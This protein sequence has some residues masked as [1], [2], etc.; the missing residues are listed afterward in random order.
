LILLLVLT[1]ACGLRVGAPT[2][3]APGAG[4]STQGTAGSGGHGSGI[5]GSV[6]TV[7]GSV[8]T[9]CTPGSQ[10]PG[11]T[12][13]TTTLPPLRACQRGTLTASAAL[14]P[15]HD[16]LAPI[17]LHVGARYRLTL[18]FPA[19]DGTASAP[20]SFDNGV[21]KV[22]SRVA[23]SGYGRAVFLAS[24]PGIARVYVTI[25]PACRTSTP[26]CELPDWLWQQVVEVV[27]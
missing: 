14:T 8:G 21:L 15:G 16:G 24:A 12:T 13:T 3:S 25:A 23:G 20:S 2:S 17:C 1:S 6:S 22:V 7:H 11:C 18:S 19:A 5:P 4:G 9:S 26:P 27:R 10:Q